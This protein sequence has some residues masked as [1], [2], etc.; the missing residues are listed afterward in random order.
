V[1]RKLTRLVGYGLALWLVMMLGSL[2]ALF[3]WGLTGWPGLIVA[4]VVMGR[5]LLTVIGRK[6][7][8]L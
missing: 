2:V 4:V 5:A 1:G 3:A 6:T 7:G 8:W